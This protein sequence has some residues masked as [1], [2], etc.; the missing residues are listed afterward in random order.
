MYVFE[1]ALSV[2]KVGPEYYNQVKGRTIN[3]YFTN[4]E[5]DSIRAK[6]NS[7]SVYY[8]QDDSSKFIGVNRATSDV[9]DMYFIKREADKIVMRSNVVGTSYPMRQMNP[10]EMRLRNFQWLDDRRPK[11]KYELFGN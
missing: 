11:T 5:I 2:E 9:I 3:G 4:G 6:G 10:F 8:A 7:E 1:N